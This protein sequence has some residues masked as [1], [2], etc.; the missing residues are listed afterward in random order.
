MKIQSYQNAHDFLNTTEEHLLRDEIQFNLMHGIASQLKKNLF[1]YGKERPWFITVTHN[2]NL[3]AA[4][5]RTPPYNLILAYFNGNIPDIVQILSTTLDN[6]YSTVPGLIGTKTLVQHFADH[7]CAKNGNA[8][9]NVMDQLIYK[10]DKVQD[11]KIPPGGFRIAQQSDASIILAWSEPFHTAVHGKDS[12]T[13]LF[14]F[15]RKIE[16]GS[17]YLWDNDGPV[18][19]ACKASSG[20]DSV[21]IGPVYTPPECRCNGYASACVGSLC[22]MLLEQGTKYCTLFTDSSNP[23]SNT[24]YKRLGFNI[25]CTSMQ[26]EFK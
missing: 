4:A 6:E 22:S 3:C 7:L 21:R 9:Q 14:R 8:T 25:V 5:L 24:I 20:N 26:L 16:S 11:F 1:E 10:L 15:E 2:N 12:S 18:S 17:I 23:T 19:L 13:P